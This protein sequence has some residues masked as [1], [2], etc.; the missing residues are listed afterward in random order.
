MGLTIT[1]SAMKIFTYAAKSSMGEGVRRFERRYCMLERTRYTSSGEKLVLRSI[2]LT[3]VLALVAAQ[4]AFAQDPSTGSRQAFPSR[5]VRL[6]VPFAAGG[7]TDTSARAIADRLGA[8]LGQPVVV[9]NHP[10]ASGHIGTEQVA[11][12]APEDRKSTP[13]NSSHQ[14]ISYAVFF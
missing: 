4:A 10:G 3:A 5:P 14:I 1:S 2:V 9:E 8:R 12:S 6:V 13:L 11:R 7:V